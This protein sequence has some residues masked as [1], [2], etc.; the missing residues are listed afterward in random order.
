V[1]SLFFM[2]DTENFMVLAKGCKSIILQF[3]EQ[4]H[5][6][7]D[8][9]RIKKNRD[10][11]PQLPYLCLKPVIDLELPLGKTLPPERIA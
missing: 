3:L 10:I 2:Q 5:L 4:I 9:G 6:S 7:V 11:T 8:S 1:T